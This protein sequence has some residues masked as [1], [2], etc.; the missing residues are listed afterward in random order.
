VQD[1]FISHWPGT[2]IHTIVGHIAQFHRISFPINF[3][4]IAVNINFLF[5]CW[6]IRQSLFRTLYD[7]LNPG[8]IFK[9]QSAEGKVA[10]SIPITV[11]VGVFIIIVCFEDYG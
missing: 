5:N 4:I 7:H 11:F 8:T 3:I 6:K 9:S 10:V 1:F 2:R